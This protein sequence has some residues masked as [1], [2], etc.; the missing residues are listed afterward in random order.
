[1]MKIEN[2]NLTVTEDNSSGESRYEFNL[3][4]INV[5]RRLV[6]WPV[7]PYIFQALMLAVF[8]GLA[9]MSWGV[10]APP[11]VNAKLFAQTN[12]V[13]LL[14]WGI[15]WPSMVWLAVFGGRVWCMVCPLELVSNLSERF[16]RYVRLPQRRLRNWIASGS[17]IVILYALIQLLVA[18]AHINRVPAYTSLFLV[19]LLVLAALTGLLFRDRAFCRGFCPVGLLL[20]TYGRGGMLAVRSGELGKCRN[21]SGKD[22]IMSCNRTRLDAR[23]C[24]SLLNPPKLN[25]NRDCLVCG[26]CIK[27]CEPDN[28]QLLIRAPFSLSDA[29][30]PLASWPVTI[31]VMLVSGFVTWELFTEWPVLEELFVAAPVWLAGRFG[32]SAATGWFEGI[33]ALLVVPLVLW[34]ILAGVVRIL[35]ERECLTTLWRRVA[36]PSAVV[37]SA[38]HMSK[39]LAKFAAWFPFLPVSL[40][41]PSGLVAVNALTAQTMEKPAKLLNLSTTAG[42][43]LVLIGLACI[44]GIRELR[45]A[46]WNPQPH[47]RTIVPVAALTILFALI[48]IGWIF[49]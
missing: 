21:C 45:L 16:A 48:V 42:V 12:L 7:F 24:P 49:Q 19:G 37:I 46:W 26:Q 33:W 8:V 43:S 6:E 30:E 29:R 28:M 47:W 17:V 32:G 22:C 20:G 34:S 11:D 31:F 23:S 44:F 14:I 4:R 39:G 27:S 41:D 2:P 40:S 13:T 10:T 3:L 5:I 15:W 25:S 38:G 36:L 18:G 9:V 1:M 35:G